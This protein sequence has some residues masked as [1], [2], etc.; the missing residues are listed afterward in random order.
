MGVTGRTYSDPSY[1]SK[2]TW[3]FERVTGGTRPADTAILDAG[4]FTAM[5]PLT[6]TA[7]NYT[8]D[9]LGT[10]GTTGTST[11]I[12]KK[13]VT[14][15]LGTLITGA[16]YSAGTSQRVEIT[17]TNAICS[18]GDDIYIYSGIGTASTLGFVVM[19]IEY[20]ERFLDSDN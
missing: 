3:S 11:W 13:N 7:M 12:L 19:S 10:G 2:K 5:E 6:I 20:V 8:I 16:S 18:V 17:G 9:A 1:G 15:A 4:V 14:A